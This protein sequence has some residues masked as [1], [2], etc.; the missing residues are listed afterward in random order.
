MKMSVMLQ[1]KE[2]FPMNINL[3]NENDKW[4]TIEDD[5]IPFIEIEGLEP[6]SSNLVD[7]NTLRIAN[8]I[9]LDE[10]LGIVEKTK[11]SLTLLIQASLEMQR[12]A[13]NSS[14][15]R[16]IDKTFLDE[17]CTIYFKGSRRIGHTTNVLQ[18]CSQQFSGREQYVH[19]I[20]KQ[21]DC[22]SSF[23]REKKIPNHVS[24]GSFE[25]LNTINSSYV[26]LIVDLPFL[27]TKAQR[28]K[29]ENLA[30]SCAQKKEEFLLIKV[31]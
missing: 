5:L 23:L 15:F 10:E 6:K 31:G 14:S 28:I 12:I 24:A 18:V 19:Y 9:V 21:I 4:H 26:C 3:E 13:K 11:R 1:A 27:M 20:T 30:L 8:N 25:S 17:F 2:S 22:Y 29:L 16:R 7:N